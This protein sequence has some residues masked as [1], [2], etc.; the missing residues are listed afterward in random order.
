MPEKEITTVDYDVMEARPINGQWRDVGE[1][2]SLTER[3]AMY[4][5]PPYGQGLRAKGEGGSSE[6][7]ARKSTK[8]QG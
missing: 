6:K 1:T 5:L 3:Q 8:P 7:S 2:V 4:F